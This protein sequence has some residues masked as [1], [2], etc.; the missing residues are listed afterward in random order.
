[1]EAGAVA[2][3]AEVAV[4][5]LATQVAEEKS[6][7]EVPR[8]RSIRT[9]DPPGDA[10]ALHCI[11]AV[12][13]GVGKTSPVASPGTAQA[14]ESPGAQSVASGTPSPSAS[15]PPT[16]V[17]VCAVSLAGFVSMVAE[18]IEALLRGEPGDPGAVTTTVTA[19]EPRPPIVP[20][21]HSTVP[22]PE[23]LPCAGVADTRL[24]PAGR[25]SRKVTFAAATAVG[26][27]T[28]MV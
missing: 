12:S 11:A 9:I 22:L 19:T 25:S 17:V 18:A 21:A 4:T 6:L 28:E 8:S 15:G 24:V 16:V 10:G 20:S 3:V 14:E 27:L 1:M 13:P 7:F 23:Q 5:P 26:L 2:S